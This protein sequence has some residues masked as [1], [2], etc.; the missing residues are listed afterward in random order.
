LRD[1]IKFHLALYDVTGSTD[2]RQ[3]AEYI[4]QLATI[5]AC[6][7]GDNHTKK[8]ARAWLDEI[9]CQREMAYRVARVPAVIS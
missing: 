7:Q 1:E 3:S 6:G 4:C 8:W 2:D 9:K 5:L